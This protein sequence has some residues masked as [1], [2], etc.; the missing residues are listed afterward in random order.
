MKP[1]MNGK[2]LSKKI[3]E[4]FTIIEASKEA[5]IKS[6]GVITCVSSICGIE[7]INNNQLH[8][9]FQNLP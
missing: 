7:T 2:N 1:Y 8:I 4:C 5:L 6:K 3:F 9:Q